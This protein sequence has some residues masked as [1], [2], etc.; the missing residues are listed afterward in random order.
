[1]KFGL[2]S[3]P[4]HSIGKVF[5]ILAVL[6]AGKSFAGDQDQ[7][8]AV[9]DCDDLKNYGNAAKAAEFLSKI[10]VLPENIKRVSSAM[11][12][13]GISKFLNS[14]AGACQLT[15]A[16]DIQTNSAQS[17]VFTK[18]MITNF[19]GPIGTFVGTELNIAEDILSG[20]SALYGVIGDAGE[21]VYSPCLSGFVVDISEYGYVWNSSLSRLEALAKVKN[22]SMVGTDNQPYSMWMEGGYSFGKY[23]ACNADDASGQGLAISY[24]DVLF[25]NGQRL[26]VPKN[27][28]TRTVSDGAYIRVVRILHKNGIYQF[29]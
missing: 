12:K 27:A 9:A 13:I 14:L 16:T 22:V 24:Y 11:N 28:T 6:V 8:V 10:K 5:F 19:G 1:M 2:S 17:Y 26:L 18:Y 23:F 20:Y 4:R 29:N 3:L 7:D 25:E 15:Q 21:Q